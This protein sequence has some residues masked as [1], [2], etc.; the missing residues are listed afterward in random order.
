[1]GGREIKSSTVFSE[2]T[3]TRK[4]PTFTKWKQKGEDEIEEGEIGPGGGARD[5]DA[6]LSSFDFWWPCVPERTLDSSQM[7]AL[8]QILYPCQR[9]IFRLNVLFLMYL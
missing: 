3:S 4:L 5:P 2:G 8:L 9:I 7:R 1:M 6:G